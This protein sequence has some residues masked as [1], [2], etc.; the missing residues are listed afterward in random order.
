M[1]PSVRQ[2]HQLIHHAAQHS[3]IH[4]S[5]T[6]QQDQ[7]HNRVSMAR[8]ERPDAKRGVSPLN[9][10]VQLACGVRS[11]FQ[12]HQRCGEHAVFARHTQGRHA[13]H[14]NRRQLVYVHPK[15]RKVG[16]DR[17]QQRQQ[18]QVNQ[19]RVPIAVSLVHPQ[20]LLVNQVGDDISQAHGGGLVER[21]NPELRRL[22]MCAPPEEDHQCQHILAE[23]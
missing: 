13:P 18:Q 23:K 21:I 15:S 14:V 16:D 1:I 19:Q 20:S 10:A 11:H 12:N 17:L 9:Q 8:R 7:H 2:L 5:T 4:L 6:P 3:L 22:N